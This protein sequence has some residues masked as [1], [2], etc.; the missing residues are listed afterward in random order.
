[1]DEAVLEDMGLSREDDVLEASVK[2]AL[3]FGISP[4]EIKAVSADMV[5]DLVLERVAFVGMQK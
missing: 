1:M 5:E 4:E 3:K 2:K